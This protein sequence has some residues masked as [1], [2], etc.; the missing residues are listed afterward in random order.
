MQIRWV[1]KFC[2]IIPCGLDWGDPFT[3]PIAEWSSPTVGPIELWGTCD[4]KPRP[5][6]VADDFSI[7]VDEDTPLSGS[8]FEVTG[9]ER[10]LFLLD[11]LV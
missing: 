9:V 6:P 10:A 3:F 4:D 5:V 7:D 8:Q 1:I 11:T 2:F